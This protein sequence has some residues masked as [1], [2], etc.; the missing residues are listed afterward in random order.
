MSASELAERIRVVRRVR[1]SASKAAMFL[2][3]WLEHGLVVE[4]F[5]G[6]FRLTDEGQRVAG[7]LLDTDR[8]EVAV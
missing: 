7:G 1:F 3:Y 5:P 4:V 2:G 8:H 6:E